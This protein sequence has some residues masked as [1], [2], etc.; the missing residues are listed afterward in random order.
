MPRRI[1]VTMS[2]DGATFTPA[3]TVTATVPETE[4]KATTGDYALELAEPRRARYVR[5]RIE[6]YGKL[7][8]WHPGAGTEAWF[9]ADEIM[10]R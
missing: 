6:R 5:V 1:D 7:P 4:S 8:D 2:E 10:V 3:G 9:F